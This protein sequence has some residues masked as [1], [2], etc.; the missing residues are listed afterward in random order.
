MWGRWA[1]VDTSNY[2]ELSSWWIQAL[3]AWACQQLCNRAK[4]MIIIEIEVQGG[5]DLVSGIKDFPLPNMML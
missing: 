2:V 3:E 4:E 5:V 1:N